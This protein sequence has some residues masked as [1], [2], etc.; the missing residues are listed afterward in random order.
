MTFT[1]FV[2]TPD[3]AD[4]TGNYTYGPALAEHVGDEEFRNDSA[5]FAGEDH[6]IL[7]GV[8]L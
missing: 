4:A 7:V 2:E 8:D 3:D 6:A 5:E 1:Y